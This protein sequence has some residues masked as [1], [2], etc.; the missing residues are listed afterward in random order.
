MVG[1]ASLSTAVLP[2]LMDSKEVLP[3]ASPTTAVAP[4]W[5]KLT[6]TPEHPD[7]TKNGVNTATA[8]P[9]FSP[10]K[11]PTK[12]DLSCAY[13]PV[14]RQPDGW[15]GEGFGKDFCNFWYP[16]LQTNMNT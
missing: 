8:S 12:P 4:A 15:H 5:D 14:L 10:T 3:T 7:E 13:G 9:T 11:S 1:F 2:G 6:E 16:K